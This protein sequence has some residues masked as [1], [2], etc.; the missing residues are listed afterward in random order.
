MF[1]K[2]ERLMKIKDREMRDV[3]GSGGRDEEEKKQVS[4][5]D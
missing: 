4:E 1:E 3:K 5:R 2:K